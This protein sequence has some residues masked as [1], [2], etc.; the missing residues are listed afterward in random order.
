MWVKTRQSELSFC[1]EYNALRTPGVRSVV[2]SSYDLASMQLLK[3]NHDRRGKVHSRLMFTTALKS[4][5]VIMRYN[6]L[7]K[8]T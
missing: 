1:A 4:P 6:A 8:F 2:L 7:N 5:K 3:T